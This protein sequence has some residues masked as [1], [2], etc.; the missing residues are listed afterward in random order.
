LPVRYETGGQFARLKRVEAVALQSDGWINL[1][2]VRQISETS[3]QAL[4]N[5][6]VASFF[7]R[8]C[9]IHKGLNLC[10]NKTLLKFAQKGRA[11]S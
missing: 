8:F 5:M 7:V 9:P 4:R 11:R 2:L 3:R 6:L 10:T 1:R